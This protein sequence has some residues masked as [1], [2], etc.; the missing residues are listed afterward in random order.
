MRSDIAQGD[1]VYKSTDGGRTWTHIGLARLAADRAH[2]GRSARTRT[3]STWR[4]SA[5][6]TGRTPSAASSAPRDGGASWQK[7]LCKDDDT[8][9]IDLAF[10]PGDPER[11]LRRA[12]AD[13]APAV[14]RL[15]AVERPGQR[16]LQVDRRRRHLDADHRTRLPR[17]ARAHRPRRRA[18]PAATASTRWSTRRTGGLYRSDDA[19]RDL[20]ATPAATAA[21]GDAAGTSAASPSSRA[22]PTSSTRCNIDALPLARRRHDVRADQGRARA[23]T[24]TTSCGSTPSTRSGASSASTRARS[25]RSTAARP[26]A[27]GTTSRPASS[28]T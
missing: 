7:V 21:S 14:E 2:P 10:E 17:E 3:S 15:P 6:R 8:G 28:T 12:L 26:G 25:S 23:A 1:G 19:R 9:A 5:I 4:R 20:D 13:A 22:T 24:T 27:P 18:Q 16:P 11:D